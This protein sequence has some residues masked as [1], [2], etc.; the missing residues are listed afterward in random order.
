MNYEKYIRCNYCGSYLEYHHIKSHRKLCYLEPENIKKICSYI[1]DNL[2]NLSNFRRTQF[3]TWAKEN[4]ILTSIS[5][6]TN[7]DTKNWYHALIQ[8]AIFGYLLGHLSFEVVEYLTYF[9]SDGTFWADAAPNF[10]SGI[11]QVEE[12]YLHENYLFLLGAIIE[13]AKRD[14]C[15]NANDIDENK[16]I[17]DIEDSVIFLML[18]CPDVIKNQC[19]QGE[20]SQ[21][22]KSLYL[23]LL[24]E[25]P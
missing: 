1:L 5:I 4:K 16:E 14:I 3:Y 12:Q 2:N 6:T 24:N 22:A 25:S 17:V 18:F 23:N 19:Q 9:L 10:S 11:A 8:I 20:I 7:M 21:D 13:R 15:Y